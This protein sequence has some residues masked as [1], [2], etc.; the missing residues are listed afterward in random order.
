VIYE[1]IN[2]ILIIILQQ[3]VVTMKTAVRFL[4]VII[5]VMMVQ[6]DFSVALNPCSAARMWDA[7]NDMKAA[8]CKNCDKYF[9]CRGNYD[10][11]YRCRGIL[12]RA[13]AE[14]ISNLREWVF[15]W[16]DASTGDSAADQVANLYGRNGGNCAARYLAAYKCAYNP[17][18]RLCR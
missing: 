10:A 15:G 1:L 8:N 6:L 16:K 9:H 18:T 7:Y 2:N 12:Q 3:Q 11:V 4:F 13:T 5:I 14:T 17:S